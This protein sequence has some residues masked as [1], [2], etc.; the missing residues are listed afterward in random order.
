MENQVQTIRQV[1]GFISSPQIYLD[2]ERGVL[3]HRLSNDLRIEM[4][5]NLYKKILGIPF[6]KKEQK[7]S[8]EE[9]AL[10]RSVFGLIARPVIYISKDRN[11]LIHS[12]LGI[13]VSKHVN[14]YKQILGAEYTPKTKTA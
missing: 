8:P 11:Y 7:E 12:V 3:T 6:E 5:V 9:K 1:Q 13:R 4:S 14:Y 10:R 2:T